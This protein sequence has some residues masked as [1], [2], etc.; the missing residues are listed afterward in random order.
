MYVS[1]DKDG[2]IK[3]DPII[4]KYANVE[5][6]IFNGD[7]TFIRFSMYE[8]GTFSDFVNSN[9]FKKFQKQF[10]R[11]NK[12][13]LELR[14]TESILY[15]PYDG[16]LT[17]MTISKE[18]KIDRSTSITYRLDTSSTALN[19]AA[20]ELDFIIR[21]ALILNDIVDYDKGT[22]EYR[23]TWMTSILL[24]KDMA[25]KVNHYIHLGD[26]PGNVIKALSTVKLTICSLDNYQ[27]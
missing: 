26:K 4:N 24:D 27:Y 15:Y 23:A 3:N 6:S 8:L 5:Y 9:K 21:L 17:R 25:F 10:L 11:P 22:D 14:P 16:G 13:L 20:L 1:I 2:Y 19:N 12:L 18:V 7:S